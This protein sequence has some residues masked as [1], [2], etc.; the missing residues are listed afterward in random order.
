MAPPFETW[1]LEEPEKHC[2]L[3]GSL[4]SSGPVK[5]T[6]GM[7]ELVQFVS[8]NSFNHYTRHQWLKG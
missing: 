2:S 5:V 6:V 7:S 8:I 4:G 1:P 3:L